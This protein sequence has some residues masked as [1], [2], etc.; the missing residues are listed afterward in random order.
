[1]WCGGRGGRARRTRREK[2]EGGGGEVG[3]IVTG[4]AEGSTNQIVLEL[5]ERGGVW[6]LGNS[7]GGDCRGC[8]KK[9]YRSE[10]PPGP[11]LD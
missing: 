3:G 10:K 11:S 8:F 5:E 9:K 2:G 6:M 1:M 4:M 7:L